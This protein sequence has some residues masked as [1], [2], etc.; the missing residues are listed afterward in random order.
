M[1]RIV[2]TLAVAFCIAAVITGAAVAATPPPL[3]IA[4]NHLVDARGNPTRIFAVHV[5]TSEYDCV[6]PLYTP[7]RRQVFSIPTGDAALQAITTWH[8][9]T[10]R[11]PLNE[12]CWLGVNPVAQYAGPHYRIKPLSGRAARVAGQRLRL[13]YQAAIV[14]LVRRA[15]AHGLA[16]ILDLH[17]SAAGRAVAWNQWPLPDR[18]Y[19]LP[20]WRSVA[21]HFK[22]DHSVAFEIFN[23]PFRQDLRSGRLTLSWHCLRDGCRVPNACADCGGR[24]DN[25]GNLSLVGCGALCPTEDHPLGSY[26]SAGTQSLVNVIRATGARQPILAPGRDYTN[27][28]S[29]WLRYEPRDRI[30]PAQL[31]ASFHSYQGLTCDTVSCWQSTVAPVAARVP[32]VATEFG[33]DLSGQREPC[34]GTVAYDQTFMNWADSAGVSLDGFSWEADYSDYPAGTCTY[35]ML[36]NWSGAPRAGQGRAVHDHFVSEP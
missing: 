35:S 30:R 9:N 19:S 4:G 11:V 23:E 22:R 33:G 25:R 12:Q 18:Q 32:V 15:H 26:A 24:A 31:A 2:R 10:I 6:E 20:F 29:A 17:W 5:G 1:R 34:P 7:S 36:A 13:R 16:V 14:A 28:L 3:R 27:D 21:Q 8:V